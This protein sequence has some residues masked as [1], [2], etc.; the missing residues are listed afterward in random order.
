MSDTWRLTEGRGGSDGYELGMRVMRAR[1][2][3]HTRGELSQLAH[4][5]RVN[6]GEIRMG[7]SPL[8]AAKM[9]P[10]VKF[11]KEWP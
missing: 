5:T 2:P 6:K 8:T 11:K 7:T 10:V 9:R 4:I 3:R 1:R